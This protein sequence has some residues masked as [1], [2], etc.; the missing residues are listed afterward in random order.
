MRRNVTKFGRSSVYAAGLIATVLLSGVAGA[1]D[2]SAPPAPTAT[3][4]AAPA[5]APAKTPVPAE[6]PAPAAKPDVAA[7]AKPD[8]GADGWTGEVA[9]DKSTSGIALDQKQK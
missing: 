5:P 2:K 7:P 3:A 1:E 4:P 9:P 6:A 8:V